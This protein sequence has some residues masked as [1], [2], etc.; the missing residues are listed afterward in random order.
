MSLFDPDRAGRATQFGRIFPPDQQW[1][2]Q[3]IPEEVLESELAIVDT[4]HHLWQMPNDTYQSAEFLADLQ[5]GHNVQAT[6]YVECG[7][8]YRSGG[9]EALRPVGETE[10]IVAN[11]ESVRTG[12]DKADGIAAGIVGFADLGLGTAVRETLEAHVQAGQGRFRGIRYAAGW[13]ADA[14]IGNSHTWARSGMLREAA[15]QEG[16]R[17]LSDM[18]LSFDAWVFH[19]QLDDVSAVADAVPDLNIVLGHCGGPLGYGPYRG[20]EQEVFKIW[21]ASMTPLAK[22]ANVSV[23]LGGMMMRLAA[24][25]Y[26][27][28]QRPPT[29][30]ELAECWRPYI[31]TCIEL[32]G[33]SRCMFESNFPV[34]KMGCGYRVLWNAFKRITAQASAGDKLAL[35]SGTARRVYRL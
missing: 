28:S 7:S 19:P 20:R 29:S 14:D 27:S 11:T 34:E 30:A 18:G 6:V 17:C 31:E 2:D 33:P 21:K 22:R 12:L 16:L 15:I 10:Y 24:V 35:Y 23:K 8:A 3:E 26:L 1:L 4:H 32:F 5:T 13:D 9:P 25:D